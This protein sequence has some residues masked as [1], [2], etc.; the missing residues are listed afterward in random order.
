MNTKLPAGTLDK[1]W[2]DPNNW[3]GRSLYACKD[4][5]RIFVPKRPKWAGWT[6]NFAH[7]SAWVNLLACILSI[8]IPTIFFVKARLIGTWGWFAFIIS[9][10]V[11]WCVL[12]W[13]LASP[14]R[15]ETAG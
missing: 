5:P 6:L 13:F 9:L 4:D 12:S 11:F 1:F 7:G 10:V 3:R 8:A 15:Y 2:A 14:K